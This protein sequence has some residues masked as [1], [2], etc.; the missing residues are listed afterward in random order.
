MKKMIDNEKAMKLLQVADK[1]DFENDEMVIEGKLDVNGK[2]TAN[3]G[4][5]LAEGTIL[6]V[7]SA[8][9]VFIKDESTNLDQELYAKQDKL[10]S[11]TNIKTINGNSVLGSGNLTIDSGTTYT[12]GTGIAITDNTIA[13]NE[14][15]NWL[16]VQPGSAQYVQPLYMLDALCVL[17]IS[18]D[19]KMVVSFTPTPTAAWGEIKKN[20]VYLFN[21]FTGG[22]YTD[23]S[24]VLTAARSLWVNQPTY[25]AK[26]AQLFLLM[27]IN[28]LNGSNITCKITEG[29][30]KLYNVY[31][32][33]NTTDQT[34]SLYGLGVNNGSVALL[35]IITTATTYDTFVAMFRSE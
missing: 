35:D 11:G 16:V 2:L 20:I 17:F 12:A 29:S 13:L 1:V 15:V 31:C 9:N 3:N 26:L 28:S 22:T 27:P 5:E 14:Y 4:V 7:P 6:T 18:D 21:S 34:A 25:R 23:F 30:T 8:S 24:A 32:E 33:Y 19:S 10:V